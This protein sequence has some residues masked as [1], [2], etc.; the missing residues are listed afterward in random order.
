MRP[1]LFASRKSLKRFAFNLSIKLDE[2]RP[3]PIDVAR[4][5]QST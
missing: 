3:Q 5:S 1:A 4:V 2:K